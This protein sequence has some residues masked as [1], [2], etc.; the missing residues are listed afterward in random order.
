MSN[1]K[2]LHSYL[3]EISKFDVMTPEE[4]YDTFIEY[5]R[6][7]SNVLREK[8][9]NH[10]LKFVVS[11]SK[12]YLTKNNQNGNITL[13]DLINEGNIGLIVSVDRFDPSKGF[14]FIT[15]AVNWIGRYITSYLSNKVKTI[16]VPI[17]ASIVN[18]NVTK[19]KLK[20]TNDHGYQPTNETLLKLGV[21]NDR[22]YRM[23]RDIEVSNNLY[24]DSPITNDTSTQV[25]DTIQ[26]NTLE[27]DGIKFRGHMGVKESVSKI[28]KDKEYK[29][30]DLF[31]GLT[32]GDEPVTA[33]HIG[34]LTGLTMTRV[35]Q[36]RLSS[37]KKLSKNVEFKEFLEKNI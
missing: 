13:M 17:N 1:D 15:Y 30:L 18:T 36:I 32:E 4:E 12:Q 8:I 22:T 37:L 28:L 14:K 23:V 3:K 19:E 5:Q 2:T 24:L 34:K 31:Y 7:N 20:F 11:V 6:T 9:I 33:S 26:G 16:R 29:I 35:N 27:V 21:I 25:I 10:N